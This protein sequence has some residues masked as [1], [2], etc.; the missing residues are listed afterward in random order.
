MTMP[1]NWRAPAWGTHRRSRKRIVV[2][3]PLAGEPIEVR[4][5]CV[6]IAVTSQRPSRIFADQK[7]KV[8]PIFGHGFSLP[9]FRQ[10]VE[11]SRETNEAD[12]VGVGPRCPGQDLNLHDVT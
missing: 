7:N 2:S 10:R 6:A 3:A 11:S 8:H 12:P 4:C 9:L 1:P 5:A